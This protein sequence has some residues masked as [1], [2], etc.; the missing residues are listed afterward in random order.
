MQTGYSWWLQVLGWQQMKINILNL[1]WHQNSLV[2]ANRSSCLSDFF[3]SQ[4]YVPVISHLE[5]WLWW[6]IL[7]QAPSV[8]L[9]VFEAVVILKSLTAAVKVA[10]GQLPWENLELNAEKFV[11]KNPI[12]YLT[13]THSSSNISSIIFCCHYFP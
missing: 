9:A 2:K 4:V 12:L 1:Q 7:Q 5:F 8:A 3:W 13:A 10:R 6:L 11:L